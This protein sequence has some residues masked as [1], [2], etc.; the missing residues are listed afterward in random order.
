MTQNTDAESSAGSEADPASVAESDGRLLHQR[1]WAQATGR[2]RGILFV[3]V[4]AAML[5]PMVVALRGRPRFQ[6]NLGINF[7]PRT[8]VS[9]ALF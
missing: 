2:P 8:V 3:I 6:V 1:R 7:R 9:V 5:T 4:A